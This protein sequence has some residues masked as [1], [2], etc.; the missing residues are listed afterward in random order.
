[1]NGLRLTF[2]IRSHRHVATPDILAQRQRRGRRA[3]HSP[4]FPED[5]QSLKANN[6]LK[7][8]FGI[9]TGPEVPG[10]FL[11]KPECFATVS[12]LIIL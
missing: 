1:M 3:V 6:E 2:V 7:C 11:L 9:T 4:D 10:R 5:P 8:S 12:N